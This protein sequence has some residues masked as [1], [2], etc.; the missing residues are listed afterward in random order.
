MYSCEFLHMNQ[1]TEVHTINMQNYTEVKTQKY[2]QSIRKNIKVETR[3]GDLT[4]ATSVPV[5]LCCDTSGPLHPR[6]P[7]MISP[8]L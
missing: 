7:R 1:Y 8:R 5:T 2:T 6:F 4:C 3:I